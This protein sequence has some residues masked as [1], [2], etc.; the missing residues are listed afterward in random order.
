MSFT[1]TFFTECF[2][3]VGTGH[4]IESVNLLKKAREKGFNCI[5]WTTDTTPDSIIKK[6]SVDCNFYDSNKLKDEIYSIKKS[7]IEGCCKA[8]VFDLRN[9]TNEVLSLFKFNNIKH[10]CI[11]ELGNKR[12]DCDVIINPLVVKKRHNYFS[13]NMCQKL[14]TGPGYLPISPKIKN[15]SHTKNYHNPEI[16]AVS[17]SMGGVDRSGSTLK[18]IDALVDW[19]P[20]VCK[21]IIVGGAFAGAGRRCPC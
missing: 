15:T 6:L 13:N 14:Y 16:K 19:R 1:I 20:E 18:L 5:L 12:L 4:L 7:C 17:V 3:K 8:I 11:D 9:I 2:Q 21:K 10:V